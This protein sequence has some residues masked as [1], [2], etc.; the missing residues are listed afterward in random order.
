MAKKIEHGEELYRV[1]WKDTWMPV[2]E[3]GGAQNLLAEF[4]ATE[5]R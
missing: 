5:L 3:L 4:T 2:S 1:R